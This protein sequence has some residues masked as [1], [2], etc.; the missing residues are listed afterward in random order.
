MYFSE[1][2]IPR[3]T[4]YPLRIQAIVT[5]DAP[6]EGWILWHV[7]DVWHVAQGQSAWNEF[8]PSLNEQVNSGS[9]DDGNEG[10][11]GKAMQD[12]GSLLERVTFSTASTF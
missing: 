4:H 3:A 12:E 9:I 6:E 1:N 5:V 11:E 2:L 8:S 7:R 10:N